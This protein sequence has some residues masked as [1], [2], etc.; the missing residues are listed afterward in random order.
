MNYKQLFQFIIII[1]IV[2]IGFSSCK[3]D[4]T[5]TNYE[6]GYEYIPLQKGYEW[7]YQVDSIV[8]N[9]FTLTVDTFSYQIKEFIADLNISN[10]KNI[11]CI[12]E[13][14]FRKNE[15]QDWRLIDVWTSTRTNGTYEKNIE[16]QRFVKFVFP[17]NYSQEWNVNAYNT[18]EKINAS[19]DSIGY[20]IK[21]NNKI[22]DNTVKSL[23]LELTTLISEDLYYEI[24]A[25][26]VGLVYV[27]NKQVNTRTN[28]LIYKG[29]DYQY[30]LISFNKLKI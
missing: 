8:Y 16:N 12:I 20:N 30:K 27:R 11:E 19:F 3:K 13:R 7:I 2:V 29:F 6:I 23:I 5:E 15:N 25:K 14:S 22:Y 4:K 10:N 21:I 28:G 24:Y 17:V 26:N 18:E 9:D 1:T